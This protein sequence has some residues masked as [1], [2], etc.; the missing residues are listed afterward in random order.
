MRH[1]YVGI[2]IQIPTTK[3]KYEFTHDHVIVK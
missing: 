2:E 1:L 3:I